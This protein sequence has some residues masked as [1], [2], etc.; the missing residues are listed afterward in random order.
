MNGKL[1]KLLTPSI[2]K[3]NWKRFLLLE[4]G[5]QQKSNLVTSLSKFIILSIIMISASNFNSTIIAGET[6]FLDRVYKNSEGKEFKYI[7]FVPHDYKGDKE[8]PVILF[9]HGAGESGSDGKRQAK[10]GLGP[11][12]RKQEKTFPFIAIFPQASDMKTPIPRRWLAE[13]PDGKNALAILAE[14]EKTYKVN[15]KQIYLSGLSMG[16]FGTWSIASAHPK[17]WAAIV[18]ICGGGDVKNAEKLKNI[19]IW[20]FH[21]G[22]DP[23]VPAKLSQS[24]IDA[25]KK[26]GGQPKYTE[27]SGVGHNSWDAAYATKELFTWLLEQKLAD[28]KAK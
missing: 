3:R 19:P 21:G 9:L 13:S 11:A 25:I 20:C 27:F 8:Y 16:G 26:A 15:K 28:E 7:V 22:A 4:C 17:L 14:I 6:G 24:M 10:V 5:I 1:M 18:P 12:I 2:D 23:V